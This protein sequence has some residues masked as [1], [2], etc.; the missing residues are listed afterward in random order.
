MVNPST[1]VA[2]TLLLA[3]SAAVG[4]FPVPPQATTPTTTTWSDWDQNQVCHP[5]TPLFQP[6]S[7]Q[8]I[9]AHI[10]ASPTRQVK[11]VGAG[12]SFSSIT[13]TDEGRLSSLLNLDKLTG[14]IKAT[15]NVD[16]LT[17]DV[18][19][20]AGTRLRDLNE[21][22]L[23]LGLAFPNL[24]ATAAQSLAGA[25]ATG[26]QGTGKNLG[27]LSTVVFGVRV[28]DGRGEVH[29]ASGQA[30]G[31]LFN[32][33]RLNLGTLGVITEVTIRVPPAYKIRK[34]SYTLPLDEM[35][36][37]H[38]DI[39]AKHER[40]QWSYVPYAVPATASVLIREVVPFDTPI[41]NGGCWPDAGANPTDFLVAPLGAPPEEMLGNT[42]SSC[43]DVSYKALVDSYDQ[44]VART[45]YTEMEVSFNRR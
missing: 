31:D 20:R 32:Y 45:L 34:T 7:E 3:S 35:I 13:L 42:N 44:Y 25:I 16:G 28:V 5:T 36:Q 27:S 15:R 14:V 11:V 39:Y 33:L 30:E 6:S 43:V 37:R 21:A 17:T 12:H 4:V 8:E 10:L 9:V 38:D 18:V 24:G 23:D 26:T 19:V 40:M 41:T 2:T 1:F 29:E 22:L